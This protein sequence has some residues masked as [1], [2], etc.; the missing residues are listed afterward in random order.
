[1]SRCFDFRCMTDDTNHKSYRDKD[2]QVTTPPPSIHTRVFLSPS[3]SKAGMYIYI[4]I[5]MYLNIH[6]PMA[7]VMDVIRCVHITSSSIEIRNEMHTILSQSVSHL[8]PKDEVFA[9]SVS[10]HGYST[11]IV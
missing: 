10:V 3:I 5:F 6:I 11:K 9:S 8:N 7:F 1:M 4:Y 2:L